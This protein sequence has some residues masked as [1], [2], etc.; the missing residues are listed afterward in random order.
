M[1]TPPA[2][3]HAYLRPAI[4]QILRATGYHSTKPAVLDSLTDLAVRY[5]VLLCEGTAKH[6]THNKGDGG[7]FSIIDVR[8]A[9]EDAGA[10]LPSKNSDNDE[11]RGDEDARGIEGFISWFSS[12]RMKELMEF[13]NSEGDSEA[14]DYL[15]GMLVFSL[16]LCSGRR[17]DRFANV[18]M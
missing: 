14:T 13:G 16:G 17:V 10:L 7:D 6:A 5:M 1:T 8:L 9:L 11:W 3:F 12:Q 18:L 2:L 4:L 15:N